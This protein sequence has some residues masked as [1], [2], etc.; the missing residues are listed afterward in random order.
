MKLKFLT[1]LTSKKKMTLKTGSN[2][3]KPLAGTANGDSQQTIK[4]II[5]HI[6]KLPVKKTGWPQK[7]R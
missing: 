3:M 5:T 1:A 6:T 2:T 7:V 4:E